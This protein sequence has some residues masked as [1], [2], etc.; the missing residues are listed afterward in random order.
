[1]EPALNENELSLFHRVEKEMYF[2]WCSVLMIYSEEFEKI[3][4]NGVEEAK[5][6]LPLL[7][8]QSQDE[9]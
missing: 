4:K 6:V 8:E 2:P 5:K 3:L 1:M 9:Q 7:K